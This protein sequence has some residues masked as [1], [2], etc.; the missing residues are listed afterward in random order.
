MARLLKRRREEH[1]GCARKVLQKFNGFMVKAIEEINES[2]EN[3]V[4]TVEKI[5][6]DLEAFSDEHRQIKQDS[7]KLQ[8]QLRVIVGKTAAESREA[9]TE[10]LTRL[11]SGGVGKED[12]ARVAKVCK[13]L[14][15]AVLQFETDKATEAA[16][17][18]DA[19]RSVMHADVLEVLYV[20]IRQAG[21]SALAEAMLGSQV[22]DRVAQA[23]TVHLDVLNGFE[24]ATQVYSSSLS[25]VPGQSAGEADVQEA[26]VGY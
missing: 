24:D 10:L 4:K 9:N 21:E 13:A 18:D 11:R 12:E 1:N 2:S 16:E 14:E 17:H 19:R 26:Q 3:A 7:D 23:R 15:A 8:T 6:R 5:A 22:G 25:D 20:T